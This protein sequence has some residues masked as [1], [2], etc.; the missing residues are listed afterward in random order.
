[1]LI[2][3]IF[4][5]CFLPVNI[6]EG[7]PYSCLSGWKD[8]NKAKLDKL[9]ITFHSKLTFIAT[10]GYAFKVDKFDNKFGSWWILEAVRYCHCTGFKHN[11]DS[12]LIAGH[13]QEIAGICSTL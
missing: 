9:G 13:Y 6:V 10:M 11:K 8:Q 5:I 7:S 4:L 2:I 3:L 12:F 1:M